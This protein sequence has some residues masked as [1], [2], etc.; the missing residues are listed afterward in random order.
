MKSTS[1]TPTKKPKKA[2]PMRRTVRRTS[3][4]AN[5]APAPAPEVGPNPELAEKHANEILDIASEL[6]RLLSD[7]VFQSFSVFEAAE[8][9][10]VSRDDEHDVNRLIGEA[11]GFVR[12]LEW[13]GS[14]IIDACARPPMHPNAATAGGAS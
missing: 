11:M 5:A 10:G 1:A 9:G 8:R 6:R 3:T 12:D 14:K 4:P 13:E 7:L 2:A